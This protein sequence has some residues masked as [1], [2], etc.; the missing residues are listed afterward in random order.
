MQNKAAVLAFAAAVFFRLSAVFGAVF[1]PDFVSA[2][3]TAAA[4][5]R[6]A[7]QAADKIWKY[8]M[9]QAGASDYEE[10]LSAGLVPYAG[11]G[12]EWLFICLTQWKPELDFGEYDRALDEYLEENGT[13]K[14]VDYQRIA[15][16]K[17]A[18][19]TDR[20]WIINA[21]R[22]YTGQGGIMSNIYGLIL[23]DSGDYIPR[24][25]R[26]LLASE[27]VK[28]Q[29]PDG[30]FVLNG[31]YSDTDVTAMA[32]Q[33]LA[34]YKNEYGDE[35]ERALLRL[36]E[37][38]K[39]DGGFASYGTEN[40]ES[41]AQVLMAL[42]ALDIDYANDERFIKNSVTIW[43]ALCEYE[44]EDGGF[45]HTKGGMVNGMATA[46]VLAAAVCL[47]RYLEGGGFIYDFKNNGGAGEEAP[48]LSEN[49]TESRT[50]TE[51]ETESAPSKPSADGDFSVKI[52]GALIKT[53]IICVTVLGALVA[54][55]VMLARRR[56]NKFKALW[57]ILPAVLLIAVTAFSR[58]E[59][60]DEHYAASY[61][62]G[63]VSTYISVTGCDGEI[64]SRREIKT[65]PGETAFGQ[66]K[67]ALAAE[68]INLDYGGNAM[69]GNIYV[70]GIGG[71]SEFD[72]GSL[73]GWT[74]R[75]NG[76][77]PD[78]SCASCILSEGDYVEWIYTKDGQKEGGS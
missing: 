36:S 27:L 6:E 53:V 24:S 70:R 22:E 2:R 43:D 41:S 61:S 15:L 21:I 59:T 11:E 58:I 19:G 56:L 57:I 72:Y 12:T 4:A 52:T 35:I 30:G 78:K 8:E 16:A 42:C 5:S 18:I 34:P 17:S 1:S 26:L 51:T 33:A 31:Q 76:E 68:R 23:A 50:E 10:Y 67:R 63:E 25:E 74:Y 7:E 71:L 37:L 54:L 9:E 60:R 48:T 29:L 64:L 13:L 75:V 28:M 44:C 69:L 32:L 47:N 40:S 49:E 77:Y 62:E 20:E 45:S 3:E 46:Q 65:E 73:S 55:A 66:L 39:D 14:P 38:Q